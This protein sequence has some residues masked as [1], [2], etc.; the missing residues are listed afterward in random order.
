M[1]SRFPVGHAGGIEATVGEL[2]PRIAALRTHWNVRN[3]FAFSKR[4]TTNQI[5]APR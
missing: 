4:T 3:V 2:G 1:T 5:S